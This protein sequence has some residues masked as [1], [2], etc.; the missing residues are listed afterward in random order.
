LP[1]LVSPFSGWLSSGLAGK[2]ERQEQAVVLR[3]HSATA[4]AEQLQPTENKHSFQDEQQ[5]AINHQERTS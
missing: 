5:R 3:L 1:G 4:A 2:I